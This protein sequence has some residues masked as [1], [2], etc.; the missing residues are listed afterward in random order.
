MNKR[1]TVMALSVLLGCSGKRE[2]QPRS[3]SAPPATPPAFDEPSP[4]DATTTDDDETPDDG[5]SAHHVVFA[6]RITQAY[7]LLLDDPAKAPT[8]QELIALVNRKLPAAKYEAELRLLE[9]L[10]AAEPPPPGFAGLPDEEQARL[11]REDLLGLHIEL[12]PVAPPGKERLISLA[13]LTEPVLSRELTPAERAAAAGKKWALVLRA[14]YRNAFAIR[15]LRMLQT[16]VRAYAAEH[17]A[18]IHDPDTSE[19]MNPAAFARRRLQASVGNIADQIAVVPF[20]DG[21]GRMRMTTRGMRRFGSVDLELDGLARDP[22]E[23]DRA[24][25]VLL[26]L[27][28]KMVRLGEYDPQGF[29]IEVDDVIP[30]SRSDITQAFAGRAGKLPPCSGCK[31]ELQVHLVERESKP[32]DPAEHVVARV[33]APRA[34]SDAPEYDH[35]AWSLAATTKLLVD[36]KP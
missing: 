5:E 30:L 24:T 12:F 35:R 3:T 19:T 36:P 26:G 2:E 8:R 14:D 15:G 18:L 4:P 1:F 10:I 11:T 13:V 28:Y 17:D 9:K 29:A 16:L 27:A 23:L 22:V 25:F 21:E 32:T 33:V 34:T 7:I 20:P 31:G 6:D